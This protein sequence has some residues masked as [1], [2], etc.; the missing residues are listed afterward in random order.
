MLAAHARRAFQ[1]VGFE[2]YRLAG[3]LS[4]DL[5]EHTSCSVSMAALYEAFG[6]DFTEDHTTELSSMPSRQISFISIHNDS[7]I[8]KAT[9]HSSTLPRPTG[10][11]I[12][13]KSMRRSFSTD[14]ICRR[15]SIVGGI[16]QTEVGVSGVHLEQ[17]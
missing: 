12:S 9:S 16:T 17:H 5:A 13:A 8:I 14:N 6:P 10:L 2:R 11:R 4:A 7:T 3:R 1:H 15:T